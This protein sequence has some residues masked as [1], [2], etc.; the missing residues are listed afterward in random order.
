MKY[1]EPR[2]VNR[3][4]F[5][6]EEV[7]YLRTLPLQQQR[8]DH[9]NEMEYGLLQHPLALYPHLE[10]SMPPDVSSS[11]RRLLFRFK[12]FAIFFFLVQNGV[13]LEEG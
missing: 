7:A 11:S 3:H 1:P 13:H 4:R 9:I 6:E 10:E 2:S 5:T 8:R 12:F